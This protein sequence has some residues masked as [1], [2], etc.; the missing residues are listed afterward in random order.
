MILG[1][2]ELVSVKDGNRLG[3]AEVWG[4]HFYIF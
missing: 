1:D 3:V 4:N 2:E